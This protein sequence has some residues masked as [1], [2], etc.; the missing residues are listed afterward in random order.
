[1]VPSLKE[2]PGETLSDITIRVAPPSPPLPLYPVLRAMVSEL[3]CLVVVSEICAFMF[4][5]IKSARV[6]ILIQVSLY[7]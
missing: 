3:F 6:E 7:N 1:M 5:E 2:P 4:E